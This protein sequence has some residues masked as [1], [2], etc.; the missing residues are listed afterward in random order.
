MSP[1]RI[2][3]K[4][5]LWALKESENCDNSSTV[6]YSERKCRLQ[7][8]KRARLTRVGSLRDSLSLC[9]GERVY[10][11]YNI[12]VLKLYPCLCVIPTDITVPLIAPPYWGPG[13][14]PNYTKTLLRRLVDLRNPQKLQNNC[15]S[16]L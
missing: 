16:L 2:K 1:L 9:G 14:H 7:N 15:P 12:Y 4:K 10:V 11:W 5:K 8:R 3:K 6:W 13:V